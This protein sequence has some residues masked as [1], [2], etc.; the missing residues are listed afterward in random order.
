MN[1]YLPLELFNKILTI[2]NIL[3]LYVNEHLDNYGAGNITYCYDIIFCLPNKN[4]C[5]RYCFN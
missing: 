5:E 4:C 2:V 1:N 3:R